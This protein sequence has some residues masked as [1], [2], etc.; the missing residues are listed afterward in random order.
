MWVSRNMAAGFP[1]SK[2]AR[3]QQRL[4]KMEARVLSNLVSEV[5]SH[6]YSL[7]THTQG[8]GLHKGVTTRRWGSLGPVLEAAYLPLKQA[9]LD[10]GPHQPQ[11][12][13]R[14]SLYHL[15]TLSQSQTHTHRGCPLTARDFTLTEASSIGVTIFHLKISFLF[16][17]L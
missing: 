12:L 15:L 9:P 17:P 5:I 16:F 11:P 8:E 4:S 6:H 7:A 14:F 2:Q 10:A 1:E 13:S 3:E